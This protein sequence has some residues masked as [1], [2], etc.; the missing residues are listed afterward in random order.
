MSI[1]TNIGCFKSRC[2]K[3]EIV[4]LKITSIYNTHK[5]SATKDIYSLEVG[6][7]MYK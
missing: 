7:F 2:E 5:N 3:F 6:T 4:I 1:T